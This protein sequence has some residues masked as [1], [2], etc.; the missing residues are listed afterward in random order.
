[1]A[2]DNTNK[3]AIW[4][5]TAKSGLEYKSWRLNVEWEEYNITMFD[6]DKQWNEN[7]PDF[8][9]IIEKADWNNWQQDN[10]Q[11]SNQNS[12]QAQPNQKENAWDISVEDIPF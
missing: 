11:S 7:R 1:M 10:N 9:I 6:N 4:K 3:W 12:N 8:N 2:Y 5:K